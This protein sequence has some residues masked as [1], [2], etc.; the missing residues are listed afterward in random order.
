MKYRLD[1]AYC[2]ACGARLRKHSQRPCLRCGYETGGQAGDDWHTIRE[3]LDIEDRPTWNCVNLALWTQ[4]V[5]SALGFEH[6]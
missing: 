1:A 5:A 3:L 4:I 6:D 2:P